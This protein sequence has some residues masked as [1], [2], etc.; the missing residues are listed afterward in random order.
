MRAYPALDQTPTPMVCLLQDVK[1]HGESNRTTICLLPTLIVTTLQLCCYYY[2]CAV[3][4][5]AAAAPLD[6][7]ATTI[8]DTAGYFG[9]GCCA[10]HIWLLL[11]L[12]LWLLLLLL[13][14]P[15]LLLRLV[16]LPAFHMVAIGATAPCFRYPL[17]KLKST[18]LSCMARSLLSETNPFF[19]CWTKLCA[20]QAAA[21]PELPWK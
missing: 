16:L 13:L 5:T 10:W 20:V 17:L 2:C 4:P 6:T 7:A 15:L 1:S 3:L 8:L 18:W 11:L 14:L 19:T 21:T 9:Y 12:L